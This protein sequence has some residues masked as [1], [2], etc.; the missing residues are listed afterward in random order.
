MPQISEKGKLM[1]ASPIRK[2]VPFAEEAKRRG[3]KIYHLNIGQPDIPTPQGALDAVRNNT[4]KVVEYSHSA[5]NES[6]RR[7]LSQYYQ[8]IDIRV[9]HTQILIT[10]GGSEAIL[11]ALM[12]CLNPGDEVI[13]PEPF[14]AN[15]NGFAV[16]AGVKIIPV[17]SSIENGFALPPVSEFEKLINSRTK[18]VII[19]NPNNPYRLSLFKSRNGNFRETDSET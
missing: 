11:F 3:V 5:G 16:T 18:G 10:T 12:S 15:Y 1:P 19:C 9:D 17:T 8:G 13:T 2:L 7:K 6:Y 4:L 14:Y